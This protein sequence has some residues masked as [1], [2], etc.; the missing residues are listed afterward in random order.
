M[1]KINKKEK[2]DF[3]KT[4][5]GFVLNNQKRIGLIMLG[6]ALLLIILFGL[7]IDVNE[8][9]ESLVMI[10]LFLLAVFGSFF[11]GNYYGK[12]YRYVM[13]NKR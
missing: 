2:D 3:N 11:V 9:I 10:N 12:L 6:I 8:A 13:F 7:L 4:E 5:E 1:I